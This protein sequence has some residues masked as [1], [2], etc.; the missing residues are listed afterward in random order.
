MDQ[1]CCTKCHISQNP[2][3]FSPDRKKKNGLSS[4][5]KSCMAAKSLARRLREPEKIRTYRESEE[6]K[7][8]RKVWLEKNNERLAPISRA[9]TAAWRARNLEAVQAKAAAD[10]QANKEVHDARTV[11]WQKAHPKA[12]AA[13]QRTRRARR[14]SAGIVDLSTGQEDEVKASQGYRCAYCHK[15]SKNLTIDHIIPLGPQGPHTL[16]NVV[17]ACRNCNSK[18]QRGR[19]LCAVQPLMLTIALSKK[20]KA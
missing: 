4:W 14:N 8:V 7:Q 2:I 6:A 5:C 10:Y 15:K 17:A 12:V 9:A 1:I 19:P 20:P 16:H 18:K 13:I 3:Q 11:A